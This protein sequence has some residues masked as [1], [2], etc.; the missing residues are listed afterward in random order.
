MKILAILSLLLLTGCVTP[1]QRNFPD[2]P[3]SLRSNCEDLTLIEQGTDKLSEVLVV[4]TDNY[5]KYHECRIKVETW[6]QWYNTQKDI[7][8]DVK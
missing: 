1:V 4:V 8:D 2:I 6:Q 7:F 3:P 5:S